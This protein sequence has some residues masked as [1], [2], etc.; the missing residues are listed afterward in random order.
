MIVTPPIST[1]Q[2]TCKDLCKRGKSLIDQGQFEDA[3]N[4]F[5]SALCA[6][7]TN[8]IARTYRIFC[9]E[10]LDRPQEATHEKGDPRAEFNIGS[11]YE[12]GK[13]IPQSYDKAAEWYTKSALQ[14]N[15][16]ALLNLGVLFARGLGVTQSFKLAEEVLTMASDNGNVEAKWNL[17]LLYDGGVIIDYTNQK[18]QKLFKMVAVQQHRL[19]PLALE[20][21]K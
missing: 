4:K 10:V 14:G 9:Q 15:S 17:G 12:R 13:G 2:P 19:A 5:S 16:N 6:D 20:K 3:L 7:P 1:K 21:I 18:A 11:R 8:K